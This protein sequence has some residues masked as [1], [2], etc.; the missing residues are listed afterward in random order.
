MTLN[1]HENGQP[2]TLKELVQ[3]RKH[4]INSRH[5]SLGQDKDIVLLALAENE[6]I[7]SECSPTDKLVYM[8]EGT[9]E[10]ILNNQS[11]VLQAEQSIIIPQNELHTLQAVGQCKFVHI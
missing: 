4:Q 11:F 1:N 10:V 3:Y 6:S 2:F 5:L 8:L 7:S 9:L